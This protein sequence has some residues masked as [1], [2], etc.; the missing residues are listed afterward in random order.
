MKIREE[1]TDAYRIEFDLLGQETNSAEIAGETSQ[2]VAVSSSP[3]QTRKA[4]STL[5]SS[6]S[7]RPSQSSSPKKPTP[8][9]AKKPTSTASAKTEP[10][11]TPVKAT[12]NTPLPKIPNDKQFKSKNVYEFL[13]TKG[14]AEALFALEKNKKPA[15]V[16]FLYSD[17]KCKV[18][19]EALQKFFSKQP[20][21][22]RIPI[23][24]FCTVVQVDMVIDHMPAIFTGSFLGVAVLM[25]SYSLVSVILLNQPPE[26]AAEIAAEMFKSQLF[27]LGNNTLS[28]TCFDMMSEFAE[29]CGI[30]NSL[31]DKFNIARFLTSGNLYKSRRSAN[32]ATDGLE[33]SNFVHLTE[34]SS[35][36]Q[37]LLSAY[38]KNPELLEKL[39]DDLLFAALHANAGS[40]STSPFAN[41]LSFPEG[42]DLL[43]Y[44]FEK[45]PQI[46]ESMQYNDLLVTP[47]SSSAE[48][49][50]TEM[51]LRRIFG[52]DLP[53]R[54]FCGQLILNSKHSLLLH[55]FMHAHLLRAIGENQ[56]L[57]A[58]FAPHELLEKIEVDVMG[59]DTTAIYRFS[60]TPAGRQIILKLIQSFPLIQEAMK[61]KEFLEE[62]Y[63]DPKLRH[64]L[65]VSGC[66][67]G[68]LYYSKTGRKILEYLGMPI[69][70]PSVKAGTVMEPV[71]D[72]D[73]LAEK[74]KFNKD[75]C[76][77]NPQ[78]IANLTVNGMLQYAAC[79]EDAY[80]I[81]DIEFTLTHL[82]TSEFLQ[83]ILE[84]HQN[85][86]ELLLLL[87]DLILPSGKSCLTVIC[88]HCPGVITH[89]MHIKPLTFVAAD[90]VQF[91]ADLIFA[92]S[93]QEAPLNFYWL[94]QSPAMQGG[95]AVILEQYP[96]YLQCVT[97]AKIIEQAKE[98]DNNPLETLRA[99][100][101]NS[102][103]GK[104]L[105]Q[106]IGLDKKAALLLPGA[107]T[108]SAQTQAARAGL[109]FP[110]PTE[111]PEPE[112]MPAKL[113]GHLGLQ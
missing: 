8:P 81:H 112:K 18:F 60:G 87:A 83:Y 96:N 111:S 108:T 58:N 21:Q 35:G 110:P 32:T 64:V 44:M 62:T 88:K 16:N 92:T 9:A 24:F 47:S 25:Q 75:C 72:I 106:I 53:L 79:K 43:F 6:P 94:A 15:I 7:I 102:E 98:V 101:G 77:V 28:A 103:A 4:T 55:P 49:G 34:Q 105:A 97:Q 91:M 59:N 100:L 12:S 48:E 82:P 31:Q 52:L 107:T 89:A 5:T 2:A 69:S 11:K 99:C 95:L 14:A 20:G 80:S 61:K 38:Q 37:F 76:T 67:Y 51:T 84:N 54:K 109:L 13:E 27:K 57:L 68:N 36:A 56:E 41:L 3:E 39:P 10:E 104:R 65:A 1:L 71:V 93:R 73:K 33:Y 86:A 46:F 40:S 90:T 78:K 85:A 50:F 29:S 22:K 42:R 63:G 113:E 23:S 30:L 74:I 26:F 17:W 66:I 45:R 70:A 19:I